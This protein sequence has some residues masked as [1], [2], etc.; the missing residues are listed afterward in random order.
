MT[1]PRAARKPR[2]L[3]L[4]VKIPMGA[5]LSENYTIK[6]SVKGADLKSYK[7]IHNYLGR[8]IKYLEAKDKKA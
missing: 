5:G 7:Q 1:K 3:V 4:K 2:D 6:F 8:A